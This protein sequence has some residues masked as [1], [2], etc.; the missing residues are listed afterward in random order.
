MT[1]RRNETDDWRARTRHA[2]RAL[3]GAGGTN[4]VAD[5]LDCGYAT[6]YGRL[7]RMERDGTIVSHEIGHARLWVLA[8]D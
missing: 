1:H 7:R 5:R 8:N 2:L 4:D 6:A 3:N